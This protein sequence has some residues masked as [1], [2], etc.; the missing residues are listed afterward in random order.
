MPWLPQQESIQAARPQTS[1][2]AASQPFH[3]NT[4][5]ACS[6]SLLV[7]LV[8]PPLPPLPC[9]IMARFPLVS[10]LALIVGLFCPSLPP[11]PCSI[12]ARYSDDDIVDLAGLPEGL[13]ASQRELVGAR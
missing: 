9:S 7:G 13:A 8:C 2:P 10:V 12:M 1:Q 3:D 5:L 4:S 6:G 11:L